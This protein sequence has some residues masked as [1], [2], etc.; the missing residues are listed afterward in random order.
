MLYDSL[1]QSEQAASFGRFPVPS[2]RP[3]MNCTKLFK[4]R[5]P[6][7]F[8]MSVKVSLAQSSLADVLFKILNHAL[9]MLRG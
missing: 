9:Q 3:V 4:V 5:V 8:W 7:E 1:E 6:F 2:T